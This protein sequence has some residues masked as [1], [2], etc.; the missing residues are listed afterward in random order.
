L[1]LY[2][3]ALVY[4]LWLIALTALLVG[5]RRG[6]ECDELALRREKLLTEGLESLLSYSV[7]TAMREGENK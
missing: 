2:V 6:G 3:L 1:L 4:G 5:K 7:E